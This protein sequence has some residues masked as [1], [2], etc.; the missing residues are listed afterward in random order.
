MAKYELVKVLIADAPDPSLKGKVGTPIIGYVFRNLELGI[1][2][3][4]NRHDAW[5]A[6]SVHGV[7][8][9]EPKIRDFE[10]KTVLYLKPTNGKK[11][12][13]YMQKIEV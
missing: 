7:T 4:F 3:V 2:E 6:A 10:G 12:N 11:I 5:T 13:E 9:M 8:N 1:I